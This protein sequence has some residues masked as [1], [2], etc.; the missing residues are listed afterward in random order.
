MSLF[1]CSN[2]HCIENTACC[3][4]WSLVHLEKKPPL[5]SECDPAIGKWHGR[6]TKKSAEGMLI[7]NHGHLWSVKQIEAG[8]LPPQVN[9][10]G[11]V[12]VKKM[13]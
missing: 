3:N 1:E 2:C 11:K 8:Y 4:Y 12:T 7:D 13:E 9:I 5:C 10:V 6:F